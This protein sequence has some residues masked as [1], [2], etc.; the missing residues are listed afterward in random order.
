MW[1]VSVALLKPGLFVRH[2]TSII[3]SRLFRAIGGKF[4]RPS[5]V[6]GSTCPCP[7]IIIGLASDIEM[8]DSS[9]VSGGV[10]ARGGVLVAAFACSCCFARAR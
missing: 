5:F 2:I 6:N 1:L 10:A 9:S 3:Y 7:K 8:L 4:E